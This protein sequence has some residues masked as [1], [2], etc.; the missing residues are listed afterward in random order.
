MKKTNKE[1]LRATKPLNKKNHPNSE[2]TPNSKITGAYCAACLSFFSIFAV[3]SELEPTFIPRRH[4]PAR[5]AAACVTSKTEAQFSLGDL[6]H[7]RNN[8][9]SHRA[10]GGDDSV[11]T[12]L[13]CR[14]ALF[15]ETNISWY[16]VAGSR[17]DKVLSVK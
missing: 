10:A 8:P 9:Q 12:G 1:W 15:L 14:W 4:T 11:H 13:C 5:F 3:P 6:P 2:A 7:D 16:R 17:G